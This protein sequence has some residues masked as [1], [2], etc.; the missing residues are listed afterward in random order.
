MLLTFFGAF[1]RALFILSLGLVCEL[2]YQFS[3][4]MKFYYLFFHKIPFPF[5]FCWKKIIP[6]C[7]DFP[8]HLLMIDNKITTKLKMQP[9]TEKRLCYAL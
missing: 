5:F 7:F 3:I 8:L 1:D 9:P 2:L 6:P 4:S